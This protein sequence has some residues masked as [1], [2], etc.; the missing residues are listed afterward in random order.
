MTEI[1]GFM[2]QF[3]AV[4][5]DLDGRSHEPLE[6]GDATANVLIFTTVDC[7]I[8]NSYIPTIRGLVE[9]HADDPLNF[10][11]VHVDPDVTR[12]VAQDHSDAFDTPCPVLI[13]SRHALA[14]KLGITITPEVAVITGEDEIVYRGRIDNWYGAL[15]KKR[16]SPTR[17]DLRDALKAVLK[18]RSVRTDRTEAIGCDLPVLPDRD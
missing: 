6:L 5:R 16:P 9:K 14:K 13:D 17:H 15:Q 11:L 4:L 2:Q 1:D 18:G 12:D 10:Y 7:P 3:A 8:A